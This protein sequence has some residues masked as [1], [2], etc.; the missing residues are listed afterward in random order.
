MGSDYYYYL[1]RF[2]FYLLKLLYLAVYIT[3]QIH[4]TVKSECQLREMYLMFLLDDLFKRTIILEVPKKKQFSIIMSLKNFK[5]V[6][7][8]I[9]IIFIKVF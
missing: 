7:K 2:Y 1:W 4:T 5:I 9:I 8:Y 3:L 6:Y